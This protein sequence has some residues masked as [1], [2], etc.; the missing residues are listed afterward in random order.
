MN[1]CSTVTPAG[2][3]LT[4]ATRLSPWLSPAVENRNIPY[5]SLKDASRKLKL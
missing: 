1:S 2:I 3:P 5:Q 4:V